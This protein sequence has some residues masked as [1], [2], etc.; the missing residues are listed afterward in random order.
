MIDRPFLTRWLNGTVLLAGILWIL[1]DTPFI[2]LVLPTDFEYYYKAAEQLMGGA[3][4]YYD[5]MAE[6]V[7]EGIGSWYL[8]PPYFAGA[9]TPLTYLDHHN[10]KIVFACLCVFALIGADILLTRFR[11]KM[12]PNMPGIDL[13]IHCLVF[14]TI[15]TQLVLGSLQVEGILFFLFLAALDLTMVGRN[16][17]LAGI[18]YIPGVLAKLWPGPY[19]LSLFFVYG[20][21]ILLPVIVPLVGVV[22]LFTCFFGVQSQWDYIHSILPT[23]I[24]YVDPYKDNQSLT[25]FLMNGC[26]AP[27]W[28]LRAIRWLILFS[29]LLLT[30][31]VRVP[32]REGNIRAISINAC[33]FLCVSLLVTPT[34]W[35]A[36]H[37]RLLFPL[38][39]ACG[40]CSEEMRY[41]KWL[42]PLT[43]LSILFYV[44]P[45]EAGKKILPVWIDRYPILYATVLQYIAF[46][47]LTRIQKTSRTNA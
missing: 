24:T 1:W 43:L 4:I 27:G 41:R 15:P 9:L 17:W 39:I 21:R 42:L 10:A 47:W 2:V 22:F 26:S 46:L 7:R 37:I 5:W 34:A 35:T 32:L 8:Y 19:F 14:F 13:L 3:T 40:F 28:I 29:Y 31:I 16:H 6:S 30:Y 12:F 20:K 23:L 44:Y 18:A 11:K 33:L 25:L 45:Q 36:A 38:V